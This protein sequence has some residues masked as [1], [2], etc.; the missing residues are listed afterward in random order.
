MM[1]VDML[2]SLFEFDSTDL[3]KAAACHSIKF[4]SE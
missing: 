3:K 4:D 1:D 2:N